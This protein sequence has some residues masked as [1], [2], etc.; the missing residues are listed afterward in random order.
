MEA[1]AKSFYNV[2]FHRILFTKVD[3]GITLGSMLNLAWKVNCPISYIAM[4]QRIPED[5]ESATPE[6][7]T[8]LILRPHWR[9]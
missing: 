8:D 2:P 3:E 9:D 5:L 1:A 4:G 6:R 7:I